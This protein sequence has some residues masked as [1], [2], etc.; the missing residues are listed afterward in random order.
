MRITARVLVLA[1][2]ALLLAGAAQGAVVAGDQTV[3]PAVDTNSAGQAEA[4][5]TTATASATVGK[6][7]VY[8]DS[9]SAATSIVAGLYADAGG[10]PGTLLAQGT[11]A[12]P[13]AGAWNDVSVSQA[14]VTSGSAYWIAVLGRGGTIRYRD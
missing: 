11:L 6:L 13:R 5:R 10:R 12:A 9:P 2:L 8:L 4:F 1:G 3:A 14:S 7:T